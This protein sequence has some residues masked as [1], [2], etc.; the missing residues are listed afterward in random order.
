M[1]KKVNY[2]K[3]LVTIFL[4]CLIWVWADLAEDETLTLS[5]AA[6]TIAQSSGS[7]LWVSF[8]ENS[9]VLIDNVVLKGS[10]SRIAEFGRKM[11]ED[12]AVF[13][14]ILDPQQAI[15]QADEDTFNIDVADMVRQN[16][17]VRHYGLTVELC[18]PAM[19]TVNVVELVKKSLTVKCFDENGNEIKTKAIVPAQVEMFVPQDWDGE[20]LVAEAVLS[21]LEESQARASVI[22]IPFIELGDERREAPLPVKITTSIE[23]G[24]ERRE[25]PLPVKITTSGQEDRLSDY[26]ITMVTMKFST[27][28]VLQGYEVQVSNLDQVIGPIAIRATAE[29]KR[30]FENQPYQVRLEIDDADAASTEEIRREIVYNFPE[31]FVRRDEIRLSQNQQPVEARFKLIALEPA[32]EP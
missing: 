7:N 31:E 21:P 12:S 2:G 9:S 24:D 30:A 29:A 15:T 17:Q 23:L 28:S 18:E 5:N 26:T 22:K 6:V 14:F 4:T 10:V 20:K 13:E 32:E 11:K 3:V 25:A 8:D 16:E 1:A 19:V 27:S